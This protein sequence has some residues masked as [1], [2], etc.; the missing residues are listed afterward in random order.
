MHAQA[1]AAERGVPLY[2]HLA[3]LA[4][5]SKLVGSSIVS[6]N[7]LVV[8]SHITESASPSHQLKRHFSIILGK[9]AI[10]LNCFAQHFGRPGFFS[11]LILVSRENCLVNAGLACAVLQH[12]QW[13]QSRWQLFGNAGVHDSAYWSL[14]LHRGN[15]NGD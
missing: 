4:G 11:C 14:H 6:N 2:R 15:A 5:N 10:C 8:K 12:H 9:L 1:G 7:L 3:D 13:R